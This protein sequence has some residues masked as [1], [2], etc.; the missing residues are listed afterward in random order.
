M[1]MSPREIWH[2]KA[3][4]CYS[5]GDDGV[6]E[7]ILATQGFHG[8]NLIEHLMGKGKEIFDLRRQYRKWQRR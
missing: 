5:E 7:A 2:T 1:G 4:S 3:C 8:S 6:G